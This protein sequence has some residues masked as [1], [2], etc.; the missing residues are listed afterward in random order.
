MI[1]LTIFCAGE[2]L[3]EGPGGARL[4]PTLRSD[5]AFELIGPLH[6]GGWVQAVGLTLPLTEIAL[7]GAR[8]RENRAAPIDEH[9]VAI[10]GQFEIEH[11]GEVELVLT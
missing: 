10:P 2:A 3:P 8:H 6:A 5:F 11:L 4:E 7:G 1:A 9:A